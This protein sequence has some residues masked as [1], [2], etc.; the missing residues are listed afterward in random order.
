MKV[1]VIILSI[2]VTIGFVFLPVVYAEPS[3]NIIMEKTTYRYCEK[4]FY[5][6]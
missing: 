3:V 5:I 1:R 2:I 6:I 4:L